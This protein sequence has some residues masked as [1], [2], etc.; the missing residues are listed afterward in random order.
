MPI[1]KTKSK[2]GSLVIEESADGLPEVKETL[3]QIHEN[4]ADTHTKSEDV[5]IHNH[6]E[7]E[8]S[9]DI[10][11]TDENI[12]LAAPIAGVKTDDIDITLHHDLITIRGKRTLDPEM[13]RRQPI[14]R[15]CYWGNF[16]RSVILPVE[17]YTEESTASLKNGILTITLPKA[18]KTKKIK[19]HSTDDHE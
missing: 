17:V 8:L 4:A 3:I 14:H 12:F 13:S 16:S 18:K 9:V 5:W 6:E 2:Y 1:E 15:E 10:F 19:V 7:G 11:E